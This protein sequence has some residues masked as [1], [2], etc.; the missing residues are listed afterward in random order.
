MTTFSTATTPPRT[1]ELWP[2]VRDRLNTAKMGEI[3]GDTGRCYTD[4]EDY[5]EPEDVPNK[6]WG[7]V[8]VVPAH[9]VWPTPEFPGRDRVIP[10]LVRAEF[11][12]PTA[13][14]NLGD[15]LE[16]AQLEAFTRLEGWKGATLTKATLTLPLYRHAPPEASALWDD[17]RGLYLVASEWRAV[18]GPPT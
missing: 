9:R 8:V 14:F 4:D 11:N 7:R 3:L 12:R 16:A 17:D 2:L 5:R 18:L 15:W 6:A 1:G 13:D 10:F